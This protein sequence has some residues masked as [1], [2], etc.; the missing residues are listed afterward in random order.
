[1]YGPVHGGWRFTNLAGATVLDHLG[2]AMALGPDDAVLEIGAGMGDACRYIA[3]RFGCRVTGLEVNH[4]QIE[5]A[6]ARLLDDGALAERVVYVEADVL[7][8]EPSRR[9]RAAFAVDSLMMIPDLRGCLAAASRS[10]QPGGCLALTEIMGGPVLTEDARQYV[11]DEAGIIQL[12]TPEDY[13][14]ALA[15]VGLTQIERRDVRST[16]LANLE[17]IRRATEQHQAQVVALGG[18]EALEKWRELVGRYVQLF[19]DG[20]LAYE[21]I[22]AVR[23]D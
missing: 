16:A 11:W 17:I 4:A 14:A 20:Q 8:W 22:T 15:D 21:H 9:Y 2:R 3:H 23:A 5:Q 6:R 1:V 19:R 12:A 10:L 13:A 7:T 18:A